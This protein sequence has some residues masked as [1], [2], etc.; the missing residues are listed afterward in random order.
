MTEESFFYSH[1]SKYLARTQATVAFILLIGLGGLDF[2]F[3]TAYGFK[4]GVHGVSAISA[5]IFGTLLTHRVYP[6][7]RGVRIN[8]DSLRRWTMIATGL[9][10]IG[11]IS[12]NWIYM[13]YRGQGGPREWILEHQ[14]NF[15]NGLMEFKEF[16]TLFPFPLMLATTFILFYFKTVIPYRRDLALFVGISIMV[17]WFFLLFGFTAGLVLA[18]LRFV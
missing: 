11:A 15:H 4:A 7:I 5:V 8:F 2:F 10:L 12:G 3:P 17:S 18:K 13:R 1:F 6:L 16:V 9:N 14:P